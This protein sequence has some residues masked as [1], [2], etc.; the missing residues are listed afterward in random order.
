[1]GEAP[2]PIDVPAGPRGRAGHAPGVI[3]AGPKVE[4]AP[5]EHVE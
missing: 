4:A 2:T 3:D 1:M 5:A